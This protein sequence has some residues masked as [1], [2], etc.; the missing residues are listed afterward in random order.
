[1]ANGVLD[2]TYGFGGVNYFDYGTGADE[3]V[4][5]MALDPLGRMVI[6][7]HAGN[8]FAVARVTGDPALQFTSITRLANQH[9]FLTGTGVPSASH[10]LLKATSVGGSFTFFAPLTTDSNGNWQ[11]EDATVSGSSIGFYR[12]S[13]P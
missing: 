10:T 9:I 2:P 7:G 8:L 1:M 12:F 3:N 13:Y 6:A 11:H 5:A 4:N